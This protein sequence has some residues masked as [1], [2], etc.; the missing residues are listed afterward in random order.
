MKLL[1][2]NTIAYQEAWDIQKQLFN[3]ALDK[4]KQLLAVQ[5]TLI[6]CEHPAVYTLGNN[7][8]ETNFLLN[9]AMLGADIFYIERGGDVTF[10]GLGQQVGYPIFDLDSLGIGIKDF[11]FGIEQMIINTVL[12]YGIV[13]SRDTK[14]A[15]VWLDV[16]KK[17]QRKIAALGFKISKKVS[18]HG[19][20]LNVNTDLSWFNK[21]VPCGLVGLG[22]TSLAKELEAEQDMLQVKTILI[23]EFQKQFNVVFDV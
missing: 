9:K 15:G 3:A 7:G 22:V 6:L 10:H 17:N 2:L 4:K 23:A 5:N 1:D 16:G 18:M 13:T 11:V 12:H 14:N 8:N 20:A 21:V 19:F